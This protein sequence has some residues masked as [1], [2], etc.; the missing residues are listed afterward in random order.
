MSETGQSG[1]NGSDSTSIHG[2]VTFR[3]AINYTARERPDT[4]ST[5]K[6][7][8][9][10]RR[11]HATRLEKTTGPGRTS[12][13][14]R[15]LFGLHGP[16]PPPS[17][18]SFSVPVLSIAPSR[19]EAGRRAGTGTVDDDGRQRHSD[20]LSITDHR[21]AGTAGARHVIASDVIDRPRGRTQRQIDLGQT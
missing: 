18:P 12:V 5:G 8:T 16:L 2:T 21:S 10:T 1:V 7:G 14:P 3:R 13:V 20:A 9:G 4:M 17:G 11:T 19:L 6:C 15:R